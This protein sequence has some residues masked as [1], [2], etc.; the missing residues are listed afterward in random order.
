MKHPL[1]CALALAVVTALS[2]N[3]HAATNQSA[4]NKAVAKKQ[5]ASMSTA[6]TYQGPFASPSA[7]DLNFPRFDLIKDSDFAPAFDAGMAMQLDEINAILLHLP[8]I[9]E[10]RALINKLNIFNLKAKHGITKPSHLALGKPS[11]ETQLGFSSQD[12]TIETLMDAWN[13]NPSILSQAQ[14][15]RI[16]HHRYTHDMMSPS[17]EYQYE[18]LVENTQWQR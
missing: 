2:G 12:H 8:D 15:L 5:D 6:S 18:Q 11:I 17:E 16:Q 7:L 4:T 1:T 14:I 13:S 9:T 3:L 10:H